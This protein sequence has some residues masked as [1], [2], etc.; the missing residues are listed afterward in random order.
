MRSCPERRG[1][2]V[3]SGHYEPPWHPSLMR[4][5]LRVRLPASR[6]LRG[7]SLSCEI[8]VNPGDMREHSS[9][10]TCSRLAPNRA[11]IATTAGGWFRHIPEKYVFRTNVIMASPASRLICQLHGP[12][13]I[14]LEISVGQRAHGTTRFSDRTFKITRSRRVIVHGQHARLRDSGAFYCYASI[15]A[16]GRTD[17]S[18]SAFSG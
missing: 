17:M 1:V 5:V 8:R 13:S 2:P 16:A 11:A 15:V 10:M 6:K 3:A 18:K 7:S 14:P 12:N 4:L 9:P